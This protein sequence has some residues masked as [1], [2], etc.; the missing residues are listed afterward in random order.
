MGDDW[1][2][3]GSGKPDPEAARL[4]ETLGVLRYRDPLPALPPRTASSR[5]R[6][7]LW[8]TAAVLLAAAALAVVWVGRAPRGSF[9]CGEDCVL[10]VGQWLSTD[11]ESVLLQVADIGTLTVSPGS[12]LKLLSTSEEQHRLKLQH[13][14]IHAKVV[15]PPRLLVVD[16]PSASAV[17]LG[18][19]YDLTVLDDGSS[20]L[21]V[22]TGEVSLEGERI[23]YVPAGA[24]AMTWPGHGP[25]IP[26]FADSP[27]EYAEALVAFDGQ[28]DNTRFDEILTRSTARDTLSLWHLL[29]RTSGSQRARVLKRILDLVPEAGTIEPAP[30][31]A[32]DEEA[33][34]DLR[35]VLSENW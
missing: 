7:L 10:T 20:L 4:A 24:A 26:W 29:Q 3:E 5:K 25:G 16:T 34:L 11:R 13:G 15:A 18:C 1:L 27:I 32:L 21:I 28:N 23:A 30:L 9:S 17:D 19:E 33:L 35:A 31:L 2:W 8:P 6:H 14:H 22:T 12:R